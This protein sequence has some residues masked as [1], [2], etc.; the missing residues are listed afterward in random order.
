MPSPRLQ[1]SGREAPEPVL[2]PKLSPVADTSSKTVDRASP[3]VGD[4]R[5]PARLASDPVLAH[6][7]EFAEG[8]PRVELDAGLGGNGVLSSAGARQTVNRLQQVAYVNSL[9]LQI[10]RG[11]RLKLLMILWLQLGL[12]L[13]VSLLVRFALPGK[14]IALLFPAQSI[15]A[16]AL[17]FCTMITL[18][19]LSMIKDKHPWNLLGTLAWTLLLGTAIGASQIPGGFVLSNSMFNIFFNLFGGV[20]IVMVLSTSFTVTDEF[21]NRELLSFSTAGT[22]AWF[23]MLT[24]TVI[25]GVNMPGAF[26]HAGHVVGAVIFS[27]MIFAWLCYDASA[28]C[29]RMQPDEYMKGVIYFYTDFIWVCLCCAILSLFSGS[30]AN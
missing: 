21:G 28:L 25:V 4:R 2:E 19:L 15:S 5:P 10:Q 8:L 30:G 27:T 7:A 1:S 13:V 3:L 22:I 26:E 9:P 11:F 20:G 6:D 24:G 17:I 18:P 29:G 14:G 16:L 23:F 12:T